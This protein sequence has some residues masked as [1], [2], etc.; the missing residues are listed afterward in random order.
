MISFKS[1]FK[2]INIVVPDPK[3]FFLI[4]AFIADPAIARP[5]GTRKLL[6]NS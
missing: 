3:K 4:A 6:A 2:N 5:N 1:S